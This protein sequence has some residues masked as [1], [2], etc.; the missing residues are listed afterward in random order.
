MRSQ[1]DRLELKWR[2]PKLQ[3]TGGRQERRIEG[4]G[5]EGGETAGG[6]GGTQ[7]MRG[8]E[9]GEKRTGIQTTDPRQGV[10]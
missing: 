9:V 1:K 6:G 5:G 2:E 3:R 7:G 10:P 4:G 8:K